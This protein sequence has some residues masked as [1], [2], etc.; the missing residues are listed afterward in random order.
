MGTIGGGSISIGDVFDFGNVCGV[1]CEY[2]GV[3][4]GGEI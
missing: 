1:F 4:D 3:S 2:V